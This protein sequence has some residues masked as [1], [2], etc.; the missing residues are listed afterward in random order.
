M[1]RAEKFI[2]LWT[3][4]SLVP[5]AI[6]YYAS[7]S[8]VVVAMVGVLTTLATWRLFTRLDRALSKIA[9]MFGL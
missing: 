2:Y 3:Y 9:K 5:T 1:H 8:E 6:V 4:N 7:H